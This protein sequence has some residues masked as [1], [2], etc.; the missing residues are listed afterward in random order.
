MKKLIIITLLSVSVLSTLYSAPSKLSLSKSIYKYS[1]SVKMDDIKFLSNRDN[2]TANVDNVRIIQR[3]KKYIGIKYKYGASV[4]T[5]KK[6]D[7][8]SFTKHIYKQS[9]KKLP[10]TSRQ[11]A[12]VGHP[13][14]KKNLRAGDLVFFGTKKRIGHVGIYIGNNKFIHASSAAKKVT[15]TSLSKKY[16]SQNYRGA[17]RV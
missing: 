15:I 13:I 7:C 6:F 14:K 8:S 11:Q 16:Y 3:A 1:D 17:R 12:T 4:N 5:T 2:H 10:R 9:G